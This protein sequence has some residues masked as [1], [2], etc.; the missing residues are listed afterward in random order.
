ME[1]AVASRPNE[2]ACPSGK[3]GHTGRFAF[4]KD[5][6]SLYR[7]GTCKHLWIHPIPTEA[8]LIAFYD[9][10]Y[11]QG[12]TSKHGYVNYDRD[13]QSVATDCTYFLERI[14]ARK[15]SKGWLLD[16]GAAT[17]FFMRMTEER[18]WKASGVELSEHAATVMRAR[19]LD[20]AQGTLEANAERFRGVDAITLWDVVEHLRDPFEFFRV[21]RRIMSSDGLIMFATPQSDSWFARITGRWWTL[22]APPQHIHYFSLQSMKACL[23]DSGFEFVSVEWRGK[24]FTIAYVIHFIMGWLGFEWKWLKRLTERPLLQ[25]LS[26]RINPRDMMIVT[27]RP[28]PSTDPAPASRL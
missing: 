16:V 18:G 14:E 21:I 7:C 2:L 8:E 22:L 19:G 12:D 3:S 17:G 11:F 23:A 26:V 13:K 4:T 20:V 9:K 6:W 15:P 1:E 10:G 24:D 5:R 27:A 25:R 28:V